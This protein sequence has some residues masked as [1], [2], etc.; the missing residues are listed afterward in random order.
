VASVAS[1]SPPL[2]TA[3]VA[4]SGG[5]GQ[6]GGWRRVAASGDRI[7][8][9]VAG[10]DDGGC[11]R[12]RWRLWEGWQSAWEAGVAS[13]AS[14]SPLLAAQAVG[15]C[16]DGP[17][18]GA[19]LAEAVTVDRG[20]AWEAKWPRLLPQPPRGGS[21]HARQWLRMIASATV[22]RPTAWMAEAAR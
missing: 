15:S 20:V 1:P 3:Q 8:L 2:L 6:H 10:F 14:L 9:E 11:G 21:G 5:N 17:L 7:W 4:G 13:V 22:R 19:R 12:A 16:P 18:D